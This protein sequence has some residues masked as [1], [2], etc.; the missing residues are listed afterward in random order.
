M[1]SFSAGR[2]TKRFCG[3]AKARPSYPSTHT[4]S[5]K[6]REQLFGK[7]VDRFNADRD[8]SPDSVPPVF[9]SEYMFVDEVSGKARGAWSNTEAPLKTLCTY[10]RTELVGTFGA[11]AKSYPKL[12]DL[13]QQRLSDDE[14]VVGEKQQCLF[15]L[16]LL[17][18]FGENMEAA[19]AA[20]SGHK[21]ST[22]VAE[23]TVIDTSL[24]DDSGKRTEWRDAGGND[25]A[26]HLPATT[27]AGLG[28][29]HTDPGKLLHSPGAQFSPPV[30][31]SIATGSFV[32]FAG[33]TK[34]LRLNASLASVK[35]S[36][37][38]GVSSSLSNLVFDSTGRISLQAVPQV[39]VSKPSLFLES[40]AQW[41]LSRC[42]HILEE[43]AA[44]GLKLLTNSVV[45]QNATVYV[46][47]L[48]E[49][50]QQR[51]V[52]LELGEDPVYLY[53]IDHATRS[54]WCDA[55]VNGGTIDH[56]KDSGLFQRRAHTVASET[57]A[58][59]SPA[60]GRFGNSGNGVK[61]SKAK[62]AKAAKSTQ[63]VDVTAAA[64]R[65]QFV[66]RG[67]KLDDESGSA[68][69]NTC[70]FFNRGVRCHFFDKGKCRFRHEGSCCGGELPACECKCGAPADKGGQ[71]VAPCMRLGGVRGAFRNT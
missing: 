54:M 45:R 33:L 49:Y 23:Q 16:I 36:D 10:A 39:S 52:A 31:V 12:L 26:P 57:R 19:W 51:R 62:A 20:V 60:A 18:V 63:G 48:S 9:N 1:A 35:A 24:S 71:R 13:M 29:D 27:I 15:L 66:D 21:S 65:V 11:S 64:K 58:A 61:S 40:D 56:L 43:S 4:V 67:G 55:I 53:E 3:M 14:D 47:A 68:V 42:F 2:P 69:V 70:R 46:S 22:F 6:E 32:S 8:A 17:N 25:R 44:L 30:C 5:P 59:R 41:R 38:L 50:C 34:H 37:V 28:A 7:A